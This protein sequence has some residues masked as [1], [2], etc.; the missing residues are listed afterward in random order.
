MFDTEFPLSSI[1]RSKENYEL[2]EETNKIFIW[3]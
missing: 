3:I 2:K 1:E